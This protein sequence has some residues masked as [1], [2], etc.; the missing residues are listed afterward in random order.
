MPDHQHDFQAV[1]LR[2]WG[3]DEAL[4]ST[5]PVGRDESLLLKAMEC[6]PNGGPA[7]AET[8][9]HGSFGDSSTWGKLS[10]DD[11]AA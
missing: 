2:E 1:V 6:A 3:D 11:Q 9:G 5:T 7:E 8:R 4:F 10:P